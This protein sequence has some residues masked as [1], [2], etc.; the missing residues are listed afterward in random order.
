M[1]EVRHDDYAS[2]VHLLMTARQ[3]GG[4]MV[5]PQDLEAIYAADGLAAIIID[6]PAEDALSSGF[7]VEGD[8]EL[9]AG[10]G[11][12]VLNEIDRLDAIHT[13]TDAGRWSRLS[14]GGVVLVLLEDSLALTEPVD[15]D[16]IERVNDLLDYPLSAIT[17]S[18]ARYDDPRL[19][20]YGDPIFY[21]IRPRSGLPFD[22][23]ESR[24]LRVPGEPLSY[25]A[26]QG[27]DIP[28]A[29]RQAL[30]GCREDLANYREAMRLARQIMRRKQQAVYK[31]VGM[32]K[33]LDILEKYPDGTIQFDGKASVMERLNLT[34]MVRSVEN[35]VAVD[36]DDDYTVMDT[37][38][39]GIDTT[40]GAFRTA[41][42][43][44][45]GIP[46]P[47]LFGEGLSGLG[48]SGTGEQGIYHSRVRNLQERALRPALERLVSMIWAQRQIPVKEP[49]RWRVVFN[50]L[51]SPSD[52]EQAEVQKIKA[53][54]R[55]AAVESLVA[56]SDLQAITPDEAR[57]FVAEA[58][59]EYGV[60]DTP[61]A[62]MPDDD[63]PPAP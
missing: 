47:I 12:V 29:G 16:R 32:A 59:P 53:D 7:K 4:Q 18:T 51:W 30:E 43:A 34:D 20:N 6:R 27:L 9:Q 42:S 49:E 62:E 37:N 61:A 58:M 46:A 56:L 48:N 3:R 38:L 8:Q 57:A 60:T 63:E 13:L 36:G 41:L 14:G 10:E 15:F 1:G 2:V 40:L 11:G 54:A 26:A 19:V 22:V 31:M 5:A 24:L 50:A 25:Q 35:T 39:G 44:S 52:K 45:S 55:K 33:T 21:T 23:H 28:W 17:P